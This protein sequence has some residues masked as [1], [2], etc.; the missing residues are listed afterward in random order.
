MAD[1]IP[2]YDYPALLGHL[3]AAGF[4]VRAENGELRISPASKLGAAD[5]E[6]IKACREGLLRAILREA[7][8]EI[9]DACAAQAVADP[10]DFNQGGILRAE[11]FTDT[12]YVV[13]D[14]VI[15]RCAGF[16]TLAMSQQDYDALSFALR[17]LGKATVGETVTEGKKKPGRCRKG[18]QKASGENLFKQEETP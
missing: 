11:G 16:P 5:R 14:S 13:R 1:V 6:D 8:D 18:Q 12:P 15:V 9:G 4:S 7:P 10:P 17:P 2:N 3:R